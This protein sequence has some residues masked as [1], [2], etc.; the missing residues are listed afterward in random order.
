MH[1]AGHCQTLKVILLLVLCAF[2]LAPVIAQGYQVCIAS[3]TVTGNAK[4]L[5]DQLLNYGIA[6]TFQAIE[7][8]ETVFVRVL[9]AR[10]FATRAEAEIAL[11]QLRRQPVLVYHRLTT[12][13]IMAPGESTAATVSQAEATRA[14]VTSAPAPAALSP[15]PSAAPPSTSAQTAPAQT[16]PTAVAATPDRT[17]PPVT[18]PAPP[19]ATQ[20]PLPVTET[21]IAP[22]AELVAEPV[23]EAPAEPITESVAANLP[24]SP[25]PAEATPP[26]DDTPPTVESISAVT[27][28][29]DLTLNANLELASPTAPGA[30]EPPKV[31][32]ID[33]PA[34]STTTATEAAPLEEA[35]LIEAET[36]TPQLTAPSDQT[37]TETTASAEPLAPDPATDAEPLASVP[38]A[39]EPL[40]SV[41]ATETAAEPLASVPA[42]ETAAEPPSPDPATE[43]TAEPLGS[44]PATDTAAEPLGSVPATDTATE[45]LGSIP[46]TETAAEPLGSD[47]APT[48]DTVWGVMIFASSPIPLRHEQ[49]VT[50]Q[51]EFSVPDPVYARAY[52][53]VALGA[54]VAGELWHELWING[55]LV[56]RYFYETLPEADWTQ[57]QIWLSSEVYQAEFAALTAGQHQ[58]EIRLYKL[59]PVDQAAGDGAVR[60]AIAV[61]RGEFSYL[62][63]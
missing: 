3:Y 57:V 27:P 31:L 60:P 13:W 24:T 50:L 46:A 4:T 16:A 29:S 45:P 7:V 23:A 28:A 63:P 12:P 42:T 51:T 56:K 38:A 2:V 20:N 9:L 33:Q 53:P 22:V 54:L 5:A 19:E 36:S 10:I 49:A 35:R 40:G 47:P 14:R 26:P 8:D 32:S 37:P 58:V 44:V 25:S 43:T 48:S 55:E 6:T 15:P 30:A 62:V 17:T 34:T 39:A 11:A 52:F 18:T 59:G 41:P 61:S 21:V 1:Y